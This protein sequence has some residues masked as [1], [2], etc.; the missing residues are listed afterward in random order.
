MPIAEARTAAVNVLVTV[1]LFYR[2]SC[3]S[4]TGQPPTWA[5]SPRGNAPSA[6]RSARSEQAG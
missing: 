3:H 2:L 1:G 4:L 6:L 5:C